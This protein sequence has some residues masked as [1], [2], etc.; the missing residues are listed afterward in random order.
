MKLLTIEEIEIHI[1][2]HEGKCVHKWSGSL[3]MLGIR[4]WQC[5][6]GATRKGKEMPPAIDNPRAE[7]TDSL[8]D[9]AVK[10]GL[11]VERYNDIVYSVCRAGHEGEIGE[12]VAVFYDDKLK[13]SEA[14][15][16]ALGTSLCIALPGIQE[17]E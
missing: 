13:P 5:R 9:Y 10:K 11:D 6:C 17:E 15:R 1:A 7:T 4:N 16:I 12:E 8:V 14:S 2:L 3:P